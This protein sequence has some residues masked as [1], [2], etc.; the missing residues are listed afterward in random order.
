MASANR[1]SIEKT[2]GTGEL[3]CDPSQVREELSVLVQVRT[4]AFSR[5]QPT[6]GHGGEILVYVRRSVMI[7]L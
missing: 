5:S 6:M 4:T 1:K 7:S 2:G 3:V